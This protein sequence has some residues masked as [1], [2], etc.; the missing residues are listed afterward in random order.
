MLLY[1]LYYL[2]LEVALPVHHILNSLFVLQH[3]EEEVEQA[4]KLRAYVPIP[5][6]HFPQMH[7]VPLQLNRYATPYSNMG[8]AVTRNVK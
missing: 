1:T 6:I 2:L 5:G 4:S 7:P 3:V 8:C